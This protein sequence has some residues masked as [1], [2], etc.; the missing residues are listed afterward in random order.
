MTPSQGQFTFSG[1]L[2]G[3]PLQFLLLYGGGGT[4]EAVLRDVSSMGASVAKLKERAV[5]IKAT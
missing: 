5:Y 4:G 3:V 1:P 2:A